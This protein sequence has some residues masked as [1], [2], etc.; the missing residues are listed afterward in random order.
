MTPSY[1]TVNGQ[2]FF[3]RVEEQKQFRAA[4]HELLA[5]PE[6]ETL[7]YV[8]LLFGDGG[9][10]KTTLTRRFRDIARDEH[11]DAFAALWLDWEVARISSVRLDVDRAQ[12]SA[13]A[14]LD[15]LHTALKSA[16]WAEHAQA[17]EAALVLRTRAEQSA[18]RIFTPGGERDSLAALRSLSQEE[19]TRLVREPSGGDAERQRLRTLATERLQAQLEPFEFEMF[20]APRERLA[21]A[22]AEG[23][24]AIAA[25]RP[26][27]IFLDTYEI[28][29]R[30]DPWLR[31]AVRQAGPRVLW[32]IAGRDDLRR[33][34]RFGDEYVQ[35][36]AEDF[37]RRLV[38]FDMRQ[39]ARDDVRDY[40]AA[41]VPG[42]P[43][44][45]GDLDAI[46]R[47]T[48]GIPLAV[49]EAAD[50]WKDG[51]P[52]G[53]IVRDIPE[54]APGPQIVRTMTERYQLHCI[55]DAEDKRALY[56]L[57]LARGDSDILRAMLRPTADTP[58]PPAVEP[59]PPARVSQRRLREI[60][61]ETL[62]ENELRILCSD[63]EVD[64][65]LL[66][67]TD[68]G[69]KVVEL[70]ASCRRIGRYDELVQECWRLRPNAPWEDTPANPSAMPQ[71]GDSFSLEDELIR[72]ERDYA[73]VHREQA[74]LH[75]EPAAFFLE[76]LRQPVTR[77]EP[78]LRQLVDR[79]VDVLRARL[80]RLEANLPRLEDRC[81][82][83]DWVKS[84]VALADFLFWRDEDEAW[85]WLVP[86]FVEGMVYNNEL[87]TDLVQLVI[88]WESWLS[89]AG[90]KRARLM[91]AESREQIDNLVKELVHL[92]QSGLL[93]GEG[94]RERQA[95]LE[96]VQGA[97][98]F[99]HKR[100]KDALYWYEQCE[101]GLPARGE[102]LRKLLASQL[103]DLCGRYIWPEGANSAQYSEI[104]EQVLNKVTHWMPSDGS[105]WYSLG[106][107]RA[108]RS[109]FTSATIALQKA[110]EIDPNRALPYIGLGTVYR[111]LGRLDDA[112]ASYT[113]AVELDPNDARP[114]NGLGNVYRDLGRLD[115]AI[116]FYTRAV[117]LDPKY[118]FAH[119]NLGNVYR[120]LGRLDD[121]IASYTRAVELDPKYVFA[122]NNLGT[123]YRDL[124]RLDDAIAAYTRAVELDPNE[125]YTH[126]RLG[127]VY[128][129]LG[130]LDDAIASYT[131]AVELDPKYVFAHNNLGTVY[132]E[133][134]RLDD[135]IASY[136]RAVEL[137]P[138]EPYTH[139]RLGNVYRELGR[140]D[141][142]IA[143]YTRAVELDPK[144]VFAHSN[145]GTVYR[146][147]GRLDDAIASYT[148]AIELDPNAANSH[149]RL[150]TV[151]H[152]LGRFGDAIA[153]FQRAIELDPNY[154]SAH[155][156]LGTLY[157]ELGRLD[158]AVAAYTRVTELEPNYPLSHSSLAA[159]YRK[160]GREAEAQ[161]QLDL[162]RPL[163]ANESEYNRAC[164]EAS[165]GNVDEA[166]TLLETALA[167]K[168]TSLE[169][170]RRD[171][172]F[173]AIRDDPRFRALVGL[174]EAGD[175]AG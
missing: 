50:I 166:L 10:G 170:A 147:L 93:T 152:D 171:P 107:V 155:D 83:E 68:K 36:Y 128:R 130:R 30:A 142:A 136:T 42:R 35:G 114:H 58:P 31:V 95:V 173:E 112:I 129:D 66:P 4:L 38:P 11:P 76:A 161:Q 91:R 121:A 126:N 74:R 96:L 127:T 100:Y 59:R 168:Q 101:R 133:L 24:R 146:E 22:L 116:A 120:D 62:S 23:L 64:Y 40:F 15:T 27:L 63:M 175:G 81:A 5:A 104:A 149:N 145:L 55:R 37:P 172:D 89:A 26:L 85:R 163:L 7:S 69:V 77:G 57:A 150:G 84:A 158:D 119:N 60:V 53:D 148:R 34:R 65:E 110:N 165:C 52:L 72:L 78:W 70:I 124:G 13:E 41:V 75:D 174:D 111:D 160:L 14:V 54:G 8:F 88:V 141:D 21:A 153:T 3:G 44:D 56:A 25:E 12:I 125:P 169:W 131:R 138:N 19:I 87:C 140:L 156:N 86:R 97:R 73:S 17:Y 157:R 18:A 137:D 61:T 159:V 82:D 80:A 16:G 9:I 45:A 144:Y 98:S 1:L 154:V 117:E 67:G 164:F 108:Q 105:A 32:V 49:R 2:P 123:V 92:G 167:K 29:D 151:Y 122:H 94:E 143:S 103:V 132:R 109:E 6:G 99:V 39:L 162:A 28:V 102:K 90:R 43:L 118:V 51:R 20:R 46:T 33:R 48:R 79:A 134:G 106:V 71:P 139:N 135:A 113:R 47:A 115:D